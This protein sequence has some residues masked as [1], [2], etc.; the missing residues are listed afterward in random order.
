MDLQYKDH[1]CKVILFS[2]AIQF[3]NSENPLES[4]FLPPYKNMP[5]PFCIMI[6]KSADLKDTQSRR[7]KWLRAG[8]SIVSLGL[9]L[10]CHKGLCDL[11]KVT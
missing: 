8:R 11:G 10:D 9:N 2:I 7:E 3:K 6:T 4:G 5:N 1:P